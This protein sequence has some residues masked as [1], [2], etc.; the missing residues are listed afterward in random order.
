MNCAKALPQVAV[1]LAC[2]NGKEWLKKQIDSILSQTDVFVKIFISD[3]GSLDGSYKFLQKLTALD[4]RIILLPKS[5]PSG[6]AG[7][8]FFRLIR[9]VNIDSFDYVG[10]SDQDDIW[11]NEKLITQINLLTIHHADAV[12][13]NVIAF[14][15]NGKER[16]IIKSQPQ[17]SFDYLFE[18]AG[19]GC[20][21][22]L[23]P[24]VL[25]KVRLQLVSE[26]SQAR[27][28]Y[29][30]DWLV[31]A[32]A[33]SYGAHW[34][35]SAKPL[36][37]YRQ[38]QKNVFGANIGIIAKFKR[39]NLIRKGWYR[40]EAAKISQVAALISSNSR[41]TLLNTLFCN[42][43]LLSNF[44]ILCFVGQARRSFIDRVGLALILIFFI[45]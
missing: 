27:H 39:L 16:L 15:S 11:V 40:N 17:K 3:D 32:I 12:S 28:V 36:L 9:E 5:E 34:I 22:L 7:K 14:W 31:Y 43:N 41:V 26:Q 37:K 24:W 10:F 4:R 33:R 19:P 8:N 20:T 38:H 44:F 1:L 45:F 2:H 25:K 29:C 42:K 35:I 21:F 18:S 13:S 30:H 23:R 6:S